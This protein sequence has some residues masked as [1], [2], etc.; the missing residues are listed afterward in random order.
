MSRAVI[1]ISA[2]IAA[3][4]VTIAICLLASP[5][6]SFS[7]GVIIIRHEHRFRLPTL[8][9]SPED[10]AADSAA[11]AADPKTST[12]AAAETPLIDLQTFLKLCNLVQTGGEA[13]AA[14]QSGDV[15]LNWEVETRRAKKLYA[16]DEVTY[17]KVTLDVADQVS[18]KGYV[19]RAKK[20]KVKPAAKVLDDGSL[21]FGGRYRSEEWRAERLQKREQRR[22]SPRRKSP[23]GKEEDEN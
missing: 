14:I 23:K 7:H 4:A 16:G 13:K 15:R 2:S 3:A 9:S 19:Y 22:P 18:D 6:S 20:K 12:T 1:A 8:H 21:E 5:V 17:D 11:A 10:L